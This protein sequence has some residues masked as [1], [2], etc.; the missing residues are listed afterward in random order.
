MI[1]QKFKCDIC[2]REIMTERGPSQYP[3]GWPLKWLGPG[4][5]RPELGSTLEPVAV[6]SS[7][8]VHL[9]QVCVQA[10]GKFYENAKSSN[11][12]QP[13]PPSSR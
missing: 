9:C 7:G 12:I 10:I 3:D 1:E 11:A 13:V 6:W 4:S 8:A 2:R 5:S